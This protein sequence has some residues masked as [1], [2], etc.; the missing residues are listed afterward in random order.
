MQIVFIVM[1]LFQWSVYE[2][3]VQYANLLNIFHLKYKTFQCSDIIYWAIGMASDGLACRNAAQAITNGS[4]VT[5]PN[6]E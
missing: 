6:P 5:H 3:N 2:K 4:L 1:L